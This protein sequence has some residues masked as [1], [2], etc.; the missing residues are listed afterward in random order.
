MTL[1]EVLDTIKSNDKDSIARIVYVPK[2][3]RSFVAW[4]TI[5]EIKQRQYQI[6]LL[7][8]DDYM[9][10]ATSIEYNLDCNSCYIEYFITRYD[11]QGTGLGKYVYQMAQAHAD[12]VGQRYSSGTICPVA[13]IKGVSNTKIDKEEN[14]HNEYKFL[15]LMYHALGNEIKQ[16]WRG[17][18]KRIYFED[19]WAP[20]EKYNK[21]NQQ[22]KAFVDKLTNLEQQK[23]NEYL[24]E[25]T[26][27][28]H[29]L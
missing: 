11:Y 7:D 14:E 23:Y 6:V 24:E 13:K 25:G 1:E 8:E 22:Q 21:L 15:Q 28:I 9:R 19:S 27:G 17:H 26:G 12:K 10:P 16:T 3:N 4:F 29:I 20:N 5:N 2:A 18:H